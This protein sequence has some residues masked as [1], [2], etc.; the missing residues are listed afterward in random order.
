MRIAVPSLKRSVSDLEKKSGCG[1]G[2][3][4]PGS[5]R[6]LHLS[7]LTGRCA[8]CSSPRAVK[9]RQSVRSGISL[10]S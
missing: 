1:L 3:S 8:S 7:G 4:H 10:H 6:E 2:G 9:L 5:E